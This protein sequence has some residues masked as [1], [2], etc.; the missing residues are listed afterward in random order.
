M[1]MLKPKKNPSL[2]LLISTIDILQVLN[3]FAQITK[4]ARFY[5]KLL[6][7]LRNVPS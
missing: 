5:N 2:R 1:W 4:D 7:F 6:Y 3:K